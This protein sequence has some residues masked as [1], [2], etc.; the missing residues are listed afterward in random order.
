MSKPKK[1]SSS[2]RSNDLA[3]SDPGNQAKEGQ[4]SSE[5]DPAQERGERLDTSRIIARGGKTTGD[6]AGASGQNETQ[7]SQED[8]A[9]T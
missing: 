6:V 1:G 8:A 3:A 9:R 5:S 7:D 4:D 2:R